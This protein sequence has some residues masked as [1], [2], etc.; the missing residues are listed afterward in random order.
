M[1]NKL[2]RLKIKGDGIIW[3]VFFLLCI[4]S[5]LEV[6]S[7]SSSLTYKAGNYWNPVLYHTILLY[8]S[9]RWLCSLPY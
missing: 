1:F 2:S 9:S 3:M 4:V 6:Y 7:A 8:W 5:V